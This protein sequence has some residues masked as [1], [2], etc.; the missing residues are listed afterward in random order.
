MWEGVITRQRYGDRAGTRDLTYGRIARLQLA[1]GVPYS[2]HLKWP[3]QMNRV[4]NLCS[5]VSKPCSKISDISLM[6]IVSKVLKDPINNKKNSPDH[7]WRGEE[8][9]LNYYYEIIKPSHSKV[10]FAS[11]LRSRPARRQSPGRWPRPS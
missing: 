6:Q 5:C 9:T 2:I 10:A 11:T 8:L 7:H 3:L 1:A 4:R